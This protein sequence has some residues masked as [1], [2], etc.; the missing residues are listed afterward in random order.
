MDIITHQGIDQT[1]C[2]RPIDVR[3][4]TSR[5]KLKALANMAADDS[6]LIHGGFIFGLADYA[7][8]IAV[9]HPNVVLGAADVKFLKP[10][11]IGDTVVANARVEEVQGKKHW[12]AVSVEKDGE[13]LFQG[14]FTCFVLDQHVLAPPS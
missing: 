13:I 12:V 11:S 3:D 10:V 1:L 6:G 8:M 14:M 5:V 4:G 2:G 9:N 7:A